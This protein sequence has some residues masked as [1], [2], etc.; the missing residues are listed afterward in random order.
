MVVY[1]KT[2]RQKCYTLP[3]QPKNILIMCVVSN[4]RGIKECSCKFRES[5]IQRLESERVAGSFKSAAQGQDTVAISC[6][7]ANIDSLS[8]V[9]MQGIRR[10]APFNA[11]QQMVL[12][13]C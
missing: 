4:K 9:T 10:T 3:A 13:A 1:E 12:Q 8:I 7:P 6:L 11:Q 2:S 5:C